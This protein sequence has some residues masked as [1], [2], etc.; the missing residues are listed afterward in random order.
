MIKYEEL[1]I[2]YMNI[3]ISHP[4]RD[5]FKRL[6]QELY[7]VQYIERNYGTDKEIGEALDGAFTAL[8]IEDHLTGGAEEEE[9]LDEILGW[10]E[11]SYKI[12]KGP[13]Y[14]TLRET[15][16]CV[17]RKDFVN[18]AINHIIDNQGKL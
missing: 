11:N 6:N 2:K 4:R 7:V 9:W 13:F 8:H 3:Q 16:T 10:F 14:T 18:K 15:L 1:P 5:L 12:L 17:G